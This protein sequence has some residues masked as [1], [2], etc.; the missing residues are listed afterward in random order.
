MFIP[1]EPIRQ[2][3]NWEERKTNN[4]MI[5]GGVGSKTWEHFDNCQ[6]QPRY[7]GPLLHYLQPILTNLNNLLVSPV[8][9][10]YIHSVYIVF[11]CM[12]TH[13][14][15]HMFTYLL[16]CMFTCVSK[17]M[18]KWMLTCVSKFMLTWMFTYVFTYAFMCMLTH[19]CLN[20]C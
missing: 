17:F 19:K 15:I 5:G 4:R 16:W 13:M 8:S 10:H 20:L 14:P 3:T 7:S 18:L 6:A 12:L 1:G 9:L 2:H 11:I